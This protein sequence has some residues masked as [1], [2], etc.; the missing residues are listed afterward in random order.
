[1]E[2]NVTKRVVRVATKFIWRILFAQVSMAKAT[3]L[4]IR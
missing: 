4:R 3:G 2:V 1:M